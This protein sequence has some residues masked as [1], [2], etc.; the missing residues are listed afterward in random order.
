MTVSSWPLLCGFEARSSGSRG[1][2]E[3]RSK[4]RKSSERRSYLAFLYLDMSSKYSSISLFINSRLSSLVLYALFWKKAILLLIFKKPKSS[5]SSPDIWWLQKKAIG[6]AK[7]VFTAPQK[8]MILNIS[9]GL[10]EA[11]INTNDTMI[12]LLVAEFCRCQNT[13]P[14]CTLFKSH[15]PLLEQNVFASPTFPRG[16]CRS[17]VDFIPALVSLFTL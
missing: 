14:T 4:E 17:G 1:K 15:F 13:F 5:P 12:A 11:V 16:H 10:I 2:P 6:G 3:S 9:S 8:R 7:R